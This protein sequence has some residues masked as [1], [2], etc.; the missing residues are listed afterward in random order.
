M[1]CYTYWVAHSTKTTQ[2]PSYRATAVTS[3]ICEF[4]T[5]FPKVTNRSNVHT[6]FFDFGFAITT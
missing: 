3:R 2:P 6:T 4:G 5:E 1:A